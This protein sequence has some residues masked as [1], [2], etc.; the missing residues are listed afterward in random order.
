MSE[1]THFDAIKTRIEAHALLDDKT[2]T[3]VRLDD[4]GDPVRSNYL[5]LYSLVTAVLDDDRYSSRQSVGSTV[6]YEFDVRVVAVDAVGLMLLVDAVKTQLIEHA[7]SVSGRVC[8]PVRL[9]TPGESARF[10]KDARLHYVDL[11]FMF[12]SVGSA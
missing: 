3:A 2:F 9:D 5:V 11:S 12:R 1:K 4:S 6:D 7:L 10:D 8:W